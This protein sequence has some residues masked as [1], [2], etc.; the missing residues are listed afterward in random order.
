MSARY[1]RTAAWLHWV[2]AAL[3]IANLVIGLGGGAI[4]SI[5]VHKAIG[6]TVLALAIVRLAW[7]LA[8]RAPPLQRALRPAVRMAAIQPTGTKR[9][10]ASSRSRGRVRV[11]DRS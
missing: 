5:R 8:H 10:D 1:T 11:L 6:L 7:R 3:I 4:G 2:M 9:R